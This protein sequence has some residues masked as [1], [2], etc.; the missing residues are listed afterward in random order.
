VQHYPVM[1]FKSTRVDTAGRGKFRMTGD[2][3]INAITKQVILQV[4]GPTPPIKDTQGARE[5]RR[6]RNNDDQP[7]E[8]RYTL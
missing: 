6:K 5:N 1:T 7:E 4:E 3:T 2:L 8:F